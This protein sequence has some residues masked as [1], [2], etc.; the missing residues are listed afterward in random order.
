MMKLFFK[1]RFPLSDHY[2]GHQDGDYCR[3]GSEK[4]KKNR[5]KPG[6]NTGPQAEHKLL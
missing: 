5:K 4:K 3:R 6:A 1:K 2:V